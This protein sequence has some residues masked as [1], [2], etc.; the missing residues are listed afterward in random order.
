MINNVVK[1]CK[2]IF[3]SFSKLHIGIRAGIILI[4]LFLLYNF[5][6]KSRVIGYTF[7]NSLGVTENFG[8]SSITGSSGGK[9][10]V[11][12]RMKG[13]PHCEKFDTDWD[14]FESTNN[15]SVAARKVDSKDPECKANGVSGFPTILLTDGNKAKIDECPTRDV[16]G[17]IAFCNKHA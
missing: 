6:Y 8:L 11:Y 10:L 17:M 15:T 5:V 16:A 4:A 1:E 9:S 13:C 12:Y 14:T 7:M 2:S 3:K